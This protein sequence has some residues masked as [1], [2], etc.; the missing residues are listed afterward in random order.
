MDRSSDDEKAPGS[1]RPARLIKAGCGIRFD[2]RDLGDSQGF[3]FSAAASLRPEEAGESEGVIKYRLEFRE[4]PAQAFEGF[5]ALSAW[6]HILLRLGLVGQDPAR[7]E[8]LGFGNLSVRAG[9]G[10][11]T[12]FI[13]GTQ[14]GGL[15]ELGVEDYALVT[16]CDPIANRIQATGPVRPSSEALTHGA[17]YRARPECRYVFHVHCP[18]IWR[19]AVA[20]GLPATAGGIDYGTPAMAGEFQRL[21]SGESRPD[22]GLIVMTGHQDGVVA[23]GDTARSAGSLLVTTLARALAAET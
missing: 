12:F 6:R 13:T 2:P 15:P 11:G 1:V 4:R 17:V 14:T 10:A 20:L 23:Y 3:D 22:N 9:P 19:Q 16:A 21:L 7:Y 5:E 18:A 8:G